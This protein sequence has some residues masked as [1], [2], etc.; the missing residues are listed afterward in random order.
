M[1]TKSE[2][3]A[4]REISAEDMKQVGGGKGL[5]IV[6]IEHNGHTVCRMI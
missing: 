6:C 4:P 3:K 1:S 5:V 2:K